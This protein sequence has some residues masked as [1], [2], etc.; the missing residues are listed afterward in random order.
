MRI[1]LTGLCLTAI[2][3]IFFALEQ[4]QAGIVLNGDF[5]SG[6]FAPEW[7]EFPD[8]PTVATNQGVGTP[9]ARPHVPGD[10]PSI[11]GAFFASI[12]ENSGIS[13]DLGTISGRTYQLTFWLKNTV[14]PPVPR[15]PFFVP[16]NFF[17]VEWGGVLVFEFS[18][19][20]SFP[21]TEFSFPVTATS[22]TTTLRFTFQNEGFF[23]LDDVNVVDPSAVPEPASLTL[24][25][26]G[27]LALGLAYRR[28]NRSGR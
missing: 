14:E 12:G 9:S 21:Y 11:F 24:W 17:S 25:S 2:C 7:I 15:D 4:V 16:D 26:V 1:K 19:R 20:D 18:D 5:E 27:A 10:P 13:Q 8:P 3:S 28:R 23:D 22:T 6:F